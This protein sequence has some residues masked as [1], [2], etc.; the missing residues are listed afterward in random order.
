MH[1]KGAD[2]IR[3]LVEADFA[4]NHEDS[5]TLPQAEMDRIIAYFAMPEM[6]PLAAR[7]AA[8]DARRESDP[9][10]ALFAK[11]NVF[12]HKVPGHGI[13]TIS[14]KPVAGIPGDASAAQMDLMADLA[15]SYSHDEL[16]VSP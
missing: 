16:R 9:A 4:E 1:E 14:L 7:S 15:E 3:D 8:F 6:A 10:F 11:R 12:P 13:V 5:L 2:A